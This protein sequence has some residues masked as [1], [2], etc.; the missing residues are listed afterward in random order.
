MFYVITTNQPHGHQ[1]GGNFF[2]STADPKGDWSEPVFI[3]APGIDPSL[4]FDDDGKVYY[5]G[6][7][8]YIFQFEIDIKTGKRLSPI[9]KLWSGMGYRDVE[10]PH[11]YK[12]FGKYYLMLAEGGTSYG[13]MICI[14][15]GYNVNGPYEPCPHNPILT[16]RSMPNPIQAVGHGDLV[17]SKDGKWHLVCLGVRPVPYPDRHHL[18]RETFLT[19]IEWR[20]GWPVVPKLKLSVQKTEGKADDT[21][22]LQNRFTQ[23][24]DFAGNKLGLEWNYIRNP[25]I[26]NYEVYDGNLILSGTKENLNS[27]KSPTAVVRRLAH[28]KV[29]VSVDVEF[30]INVDG[31]EAGLVL[32]LGGS[33]VDEPK[34]GYHYEIALK[35]IDGCKHIIVRRQVGTISQIDYTKKMI[36]NKVTLKLDIGP[37]HV[38]FGYKYIDGK[39]YNNIAQGEMHLLSTEAGGT[40]TGLMLG[41]YVVGDKAK[42]KFSNFRYK[43]KK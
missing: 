25:I 21:Y 8:G 36:A 5:T 42:A 30:N 24:D 1:G 19:E 38:D 27:F 12:M 35:N 43:A 33:F 40:F 9:H 10:A 7:D 3:D 17:E 31:D 2:V 13:H 22:P 14:A 26:D 37:K 11:V 39:Q 41:L 34:R 28:M 29:A 32:F 15:R 6:T 23:N 4:F 16:H 18:G 20:N